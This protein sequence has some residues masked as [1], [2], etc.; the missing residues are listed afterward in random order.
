MVSIK[1]LTDLRNYGEVLRDCAD[2]H[3]VYLTRNGRGA[4]VLLE[5]KEYEKQQTMLNLFAKLAEGE[6]S[7]RNESD[8][9]TTEEL[10]EKLG[11]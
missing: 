4:Y 3:P 7:V 8:W 1:P 2:G 10:R 5:M 9:L 11:V 6:A